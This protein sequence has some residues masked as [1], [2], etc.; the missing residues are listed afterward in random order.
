MKRLLVIAAAIACVSASASLADET[1]KD[2][3]GVTTED[4]LKTGA[5][6]G[7]GDVKTN[8]GDQKNGKVR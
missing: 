8:K 3:N 7:V 6:V 2:K 5:A 4:E 1:K